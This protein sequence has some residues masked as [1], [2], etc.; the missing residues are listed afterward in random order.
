MQRKGSRSLAASG[1]R[2][3]WLL[4]VPVINSGRAAPA[5]ERFIRL[6]RSSLCT[7]QLTEHRTALTYDRAQ[8]SAC[9]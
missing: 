5:F 4:P 3:V 6:N 7:T 2:L 9:L 8:L 1:G